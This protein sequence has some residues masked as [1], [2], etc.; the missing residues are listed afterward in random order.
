LKVAALYDVH[1]NVRALEAVLAEVEAD[2]IVFGGDIVAGAFPVETLEV[3][4]SVPN[5]RFVR[6]NADELDRAATVAK[7]DAERRWLI[8]RLDA[9]SRRWLAELPF[10]FVCDDTLYVHA[11][12][13]DVTGRVMETTPDEEIAALVA[14]IDERRVVSGHV[15]MQFVRRVTGVE[16]IGAGSVGSAYEDLPGAYWATI[17]D[18]EVEFKRTE[19]DWAAY[20]RA[21]RA[22]DYPLRDEVLTPTTRAEAI[23]AFST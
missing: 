7:W 16:W 23:A 1:A 20:E 11:N 5:A 4:R 13:L 21:V 8:D 17:D 2:V 12:P 10:S 3:V 18:A 19:Y 14:P 6:G 15:H 22:G 9:G